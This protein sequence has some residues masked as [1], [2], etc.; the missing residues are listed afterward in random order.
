MAGLT[1]SIAFELGPEIRCNAIA[2][3]L[4]NTAMVESAGGVEALTGMIE[5]SPLKRYGNPEDIAS[6]ALFLVSDD[7]SFITGQVI[8]VDGGFEC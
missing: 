3:G 2:P 1:K 5:G 6:V 7:S 8:K 4:I